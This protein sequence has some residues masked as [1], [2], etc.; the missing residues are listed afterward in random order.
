M[1]KQA[2]EKLG[3]KQMEQAKVLAQAALDSS[4]KIWLAGLGAFALA[5]KEGM[6]MF[7]SLV[8]QGAEL[9]AKTKKAAATTAE[10]AKDAAMHKAGEMKAK[11]EATLNNLEQVFED[12]V[13]RALNRLGVYTASDVAQLAARVSELSTAVDSLLKRKGGSTSDVV[14]AAGKT[15]QQAVKTAHRTTSKAVK[16]VAKTVRDTLK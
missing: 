2:K 12:R 8:E 4:H 11:A 7:E 5:Q 3:S 14:K 16:K 6:K 13:A 15:A 1:L 9:E 10:A